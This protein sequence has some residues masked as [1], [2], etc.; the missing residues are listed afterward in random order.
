MRS[1]H[2][3]LCAADLLA[4]LDRLDLSDEEQ[5]AVTSAVSSATMLRARVHDV[6]SM[7]GVADANEEGNHIGLSLV[8]PRNPS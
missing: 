8:P 7:R 5:I 2:V 3:R 6:L 4:A 1:N